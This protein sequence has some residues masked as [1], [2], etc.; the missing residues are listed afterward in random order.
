MLRQFLAQFLLNKG[1]VS[2]QQVLE[3]LDQDDLECIS[4]GVV[5][6]YEGWMT[7][8]QVAEVEKLQCDQDQDFGE[9]AIK[10]GYLTTEQA[11]KLPITH[12][13]VSLS[14]IQSVINKGFMSS[15]KMQEVLAEYRRLNDETEFTQ[16]QVSKGGLGE[17][18]LEELYEEYIHTFLGGM[19]K[20][21]G[22]AGIVV[23]STPLD[24][25]GKWLISQ[26]I[27]GDISLGIGVL[28]D[29]NVLYKLSS[30]YSKESTEG[31]EGLALD[32][33]AEFLNVLNGLF[34][35]AL[36]NEK[37]DADLE[38]QKHSKNQQPIGSDQICVNIETKIGLVQLT[39]AT[40]GMQ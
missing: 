37:I 16:G 15:E 23:E 13:N 32:C 12:E 8:E 30:M 29:E 1:L 31:N 39:L 35:I 25:V 27:Y 20:F 40:D 3:I 11:E 10:K 22:C 4:P 36:S 26:R 21:T 9:V 17:L 6:M 28:L 24:A 38:P 19:K 14:F 33:I 18:Q 5:A 34:V 2:R 7:A